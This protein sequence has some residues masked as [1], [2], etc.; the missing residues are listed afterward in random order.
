M[1]S[2]LV[3]KDAFNSLPED[4]QEGLIEASLRYQEVERERR[5]REDALITVQAMHEDGIIVRAL[6]DSLS[7]IIQEKAP[8]YTKEW[9]EEVGKGSVEAY[10]VIKEVLGWK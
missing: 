5:A 1:D 2:I 3:N 4:V 7:R 8:A 6:P 10:N 9:A